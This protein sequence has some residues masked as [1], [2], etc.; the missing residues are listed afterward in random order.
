L[1][2]KKK[3]KKKEMYK[4][5]IISTKKRIR[6]NDGTVLRFD[7][8]RAL[9]FSDQLKFL[10]TRIRGPINQELRKLPLFK[11][12]ISYTEVIL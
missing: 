4:A 10:G 2:G 6:R 8:N 1:I 3:S 9:I 11:Q 5:L 7:K 12:L